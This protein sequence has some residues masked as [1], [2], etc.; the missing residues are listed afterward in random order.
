MVN[1]AGSFP[2][3]TDLTGPTRF[4]AQ[5]SRKSSE[6]A[7]SSCTC[8]SVRK[9]ASRRAGGGAPMI[10][11]YSAGWPCWTQSHDVELVANLASGDILTATDSVVH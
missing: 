7:N 10:R 11:E 6:T 9:D 3:Q 1:S 8:G 4:S 2:L 5:G